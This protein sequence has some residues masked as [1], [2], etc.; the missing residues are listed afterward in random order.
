MKPRS[1]AALAVA[2]TLVTGCSGGGES[3]EESRHEATVEPSPTTEAPPL[4]SY[5]GLLATDIWAQYDGEKIDCPALWVKKGITK[6]DQVLLHGA[7]GEIA[8]AGRVGPVPAEMKDEVKP[9]ESVCLLVAELS[10]IERGGKFYTASIGD[11]E[12]AAIP[13]TEVSERRFVI[14][15]D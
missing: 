1:W 9:P 3:S 5:V 8:A 6:G 15:I 11:W 10:D 12:S 14:E 2:A 4:D 13:E 7:G